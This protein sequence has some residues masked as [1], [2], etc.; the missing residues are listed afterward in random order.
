MDYQLLKHPGISTVSF[1]KISAGK[2]LCNVPV[3]TDELD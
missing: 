1:E 3:A 2:C